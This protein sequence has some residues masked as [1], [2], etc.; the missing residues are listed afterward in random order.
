M[1]GQISMRLARDILTQLRMIF[2]KY[3]AIG[4]AATILFSGIVG[5]IASV[6]VLD[7]MGRNE[8]MSTDQRIFA[9]FSATA[10]ASLVTAVAGCASYLEGVY[11]MQL[12]KG[13]LHMLLDSR[14]TPDDVSGQI[15]YFRAFQDDQSWAQLPF[16][17]FFALTVTDE[18]RLVNTLSRVREVFAIGRQGEVV[19]PVGARRMYFADAEWQDAATNM[20]R[21]AAFVLVRPNRTTWLLWELQRVVE[22]CR[23]DQLI[24]WLPVGLDKDRWRQLRHDAKTQCGLELPESITGNLFLLFGER[25]SCYPIRSIPDLIYEMRSY[26]T[27]PIRAYED[28]PKLSCLRCKVRPLPH[29]IAERVCKLC[30]QPLAFRTNP[31]NDAL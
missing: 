13:Y 12:A 10:I 3:V 5:V 31:S 6:I 22:I 15:A 26:K 29:E 24:V 1:P 18:E 9:A 19:P 4:G 11:N 14:L 8:A 28:G 17:S 23:P 30:N 27:K 2:W 25:W 21:N 7:S 16:G 20:M